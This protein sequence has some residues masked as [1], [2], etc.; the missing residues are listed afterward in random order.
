MYQ[1]YQQ[2]KMLEIKAKACKQF[3]DDFRAIVYYL[4]FAV[5]W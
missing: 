1:I 2:P 4:Q 5:Q 3:P